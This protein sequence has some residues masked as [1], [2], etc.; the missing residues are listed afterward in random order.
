[1]KN[2][3]FVSS[4]NPGLEDS[5]N[6]KSS[7]EE[8][9]ARSESFSSERSDSGVDIDVVKHYQ[10]PRF[11]DDLKYTL[12]DNSALSPFQANESS[13]RVLGQ[14][15]PINSFNKELNRN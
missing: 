11:F 10:K 13:V 2:Y 15:S 6:S 1:M 5:K 8:L 4:N 9:P 7:G 14:N 12:N 3:A